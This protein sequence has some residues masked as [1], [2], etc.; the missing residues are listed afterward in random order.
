MKVNSKLLEELP[1]YVEPICLLIGFMVSCLFDYGVEVNNCFVTDLVSFF[2]Y[3]KIYF[4][5]GSFIPMLSYLLKLG[6]TIG[7]LLKSE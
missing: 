1:Q 7:I 5:L 3:K 4:L 6:V 2:F